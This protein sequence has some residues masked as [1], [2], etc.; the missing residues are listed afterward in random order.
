MNFSGKP[1]T[2]QYHD[3]IEENILE[4]EA[5]QV[6]KLISVVIKVRIM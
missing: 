6:S 5:E 3:N 4:T 2:K 1:W